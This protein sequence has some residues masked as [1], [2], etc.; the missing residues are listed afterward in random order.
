MRSKDLRSLMILILIFKF[1]EGISKLHHQR[2][3]TCALPRARFLGDFF[4]RKDILN[5]LGI[6]V[7]KTLGRSYRDFTEVTTL[8]NELQHTAFK[9]FRFQALLDDCPL[10]VILAVSFIVRI[11]FSTTAWKAKK[12]SDAMKFMAE[13][14]TIYGMPIQTANFFMIVFQ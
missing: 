13:S 7:P 1:F 12:Q 14:F 4:Y 8:W 6:P 2:V 5:S 3:S 11:G 9:W 10:S